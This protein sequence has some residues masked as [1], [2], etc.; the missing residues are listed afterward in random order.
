MSMAGGLSA[1]FGMKAET[2]YG[3]AV[4][5]DRFLEFNSESVAQSIERIESA[6]LRPARRVLSTTDWVAGKKSIGGDVDFEVQSQGFGL[7]LKHCLGSVASAQPNAGSA[8]TVYEH[9]LKVGALDGLSFTGQ[10][11]RSDTGGTIR[12]FTYAGCKVASWELSC[13]VDG[14]LMLKTS[15]LGQSETTAT[16]LATASYATNPTPL[17]FTGATIQIGG[18]SYDVKN[19]DL[20][21]NNSLKEDRYFMRGSTNSAL[22]EEPLEGAGLREIGG[23]I[24]IEFGSLTPYTLF[25]AGTVGAVTASFQG[26]N[27]ALSYNYA[28]EVTLPAVRFDGTTPVVSGPDLIDQS[29]PYKCL[30]DGTSTTPVQI[31]YRTT[32]TTP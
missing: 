19:F 21:A 31:V 12:A 5:V 17:A 32:D 15:L 23:N 28:L 18:V 7:L 3:T 13:S 4:T 16:G 6:G 9:T 1:Q 22:R 14:F 24:E 26:T 25:T 2:T 29:L 30:D 10:F 11:A 27:I 8:P 20:S